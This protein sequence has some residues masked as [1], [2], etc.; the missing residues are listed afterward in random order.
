M[1]ELMG[2]KNTC[3]DG[4]SVEFEVLP[5]TKS[6]EELSAE[7]WEINMALEAVEQQL[8]E[9]QTE[10]DKYN[11]EINHLTNTA[12]GL[13]YTVAVACGILTGILDSLWV[14]DFSLE[15][16]NTW[17]SEKTNDMVIR[18]AEMA[19]KLKGEETAEFDLQSAVR[20]LEKM[21]PIAADKA[22]GFFGGGLQHHL[23][24]FSHHP[25]IVGLV[26]SLLTQFTGQVYGT[27]T[28]GFFTCVTVD[29]ELI[30]NNFP[31]KIF[32]GVIQW[33]FHL[34]SDVAGSSGSM[35][36]G[37][38]GTGLPGPFVSLIK[39]VSAL[40]FFK[41]LDENG[42]KEFSVWISK[43]F[44]G[45]LLG[46]R[47]KS[48]KVIE[49][50][51]FDWRT[52]LG[53]GH[54]VGKQA[55]PIIINECVVRS[56]YFIRHLML[57]IKKENV[58]TFT[59][60][61][62]IDVNRILPFRNRTIIRMLTISSGTFTAVDIADAVIRS[63]IKSGGFQG[64]EFIKNMIL[65]VNIVG[66]GRLVVALGA[67]IYMEAKQSRK[68]NDRIYLYTRQISLT[69][70][71]VF[72]KEANMWIAAV[73]AEEAIDRAYSLM[74]KS[75]MFYIGSMQEISEKLKKVGIYQPEIKRKNPKLI[76]SILD[77]LNGD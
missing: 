21:F 63:A 16:A 70:A 77:V 67:D 35:Q 42:N 30:G 57:E 58:Q 3:D 17:G 49:A 28:Q 48:G 1:D 31:E 39:E 46:K 55:V 40:P 50:V 37:S 12:D 66:V 11:I 47:D 15:A 62:K 18:A 13:D 60:L 38:M 59:D 69:N 56:F 6:L 2:L 45:T 51:K 44:N 41:K 19:A 72:Y 68:R 54:W 4:F 20:Y 32:L 33:F 24:D 65:R 74:E 53:I 75:A 25:T 73:D 23:R 8:A 71:R 34:I 9:G 26:F 14:G 22:T 27:N 5:S 52:E 76:D 29:S 43:L 10:I 7:K 64:E 61:K 36:K